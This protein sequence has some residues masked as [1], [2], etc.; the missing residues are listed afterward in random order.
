MQLFFDG[1]HSTSSNT[2][3][4]RFGFH[5]LEP[6]VL[7]ITLCCTAHENVKLCSKLCLTVAKWQCISV[8]FCCWKQYCIQVYIEQERFI[9]YCIGTWEKLVAVVLLLVV[10]ILP[11]WAVIDTCKADNHTHMS[12]S[13][14]R[15][16]W[17]CTAAAALIL[18]PHCALCPI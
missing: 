14:S 6:I 9:F 16:A 3:C 11:H 5:P 18:C 15:Y 17:R 8:K 13:T 7:K 4:Y 10:A 12:S 1:C 2:G